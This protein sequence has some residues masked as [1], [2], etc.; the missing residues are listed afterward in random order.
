LQAGLGYK[1]DPG[2]AVESG[3]VRPM[4]DPRVTVKYGTETPME[5][6]GVTVKYGTERPTKTA[7]VHEGWGPGERTRKGKERPMETDSVQA[8]YTF[9]TQ[10][11]FL[12]AYSTSEGK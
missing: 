6:P 9:P 12:I 7:P 5:D 1:L 4:E 8:T 2:V 10:A 11:D 3:T